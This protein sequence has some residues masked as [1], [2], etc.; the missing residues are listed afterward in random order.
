MPS[1]RVGVTQAT[2]ESQKGRNHFSV[3]NAAQRAGVLIAKKGRLDS[4][5]LATK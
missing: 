4:L 1:R 5:A 2:Q 3:S